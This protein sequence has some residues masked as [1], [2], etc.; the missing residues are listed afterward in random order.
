MD[1]QVDPIIKE[2]EEFMERLK[3]KY[4]VECSVIAIKTKDNHPFVHLTGEQLD[5]TELAAATADRMRND[6]LRRIG[7]R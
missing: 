2:C 3:E 1:D 4:G 5:Y 6:V 7:V